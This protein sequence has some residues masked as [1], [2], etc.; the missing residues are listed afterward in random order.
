MVLVV[1]VLMLIS[2][3]TLAI[4]WTTSELALVF[5][6]MGSAAAAGVVLTISI[7]RNRPEEVFSGGGTH[8]DADDSWE[9][10]PARS[11]RIARPAA[12]P[13]S[14]SV[15]VEGDVDE[16]DLS[17]DDDLDDEEYDDEEGLQS[18]EDLPIAD[19]DELS[20]SE[21][22][23]LLEELDLDELEEVREHEVAN[24]S[25]RTVLGQIDSLLDELSVAEPAAQ[26]GE[27]LS[28]E[29][30]DEEY[31][32]EEEEE[33]EELD[34]EEEYEDEEDEELEDE[35]EDEEPAGEDSFPIA[36][37]DDLKSSEILPLL[38]QLYPD[39]LEI[40]WEHENATRARELVLAR[41]DVLLEEEEVPPPRRTAPKP[42]RPAARKPAAPARRPAAQEAAPPRRPAAKKP[43]APVRKPA[44]PARPP[45]RKAVPAR[46]AARKATAKAKAPTRKVASAVKKT[47]KKSVA[48]G[49]PIKN[50][51]KLAVPDIVRRLKRLSAAE[52]KAVRTYERR[53]KGRVTLLDQ[54]DSFIRG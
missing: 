45:A 16:A 8:D 10:R 14:R 46:P 47:V 42:P 29:E 30:D 38:P 33:L 15:F 1:M 54:I 2:M 48:A 53:N 24:R 5:A 21:I 27:A 41:I 7:L 6:S 51:D 28:Y 50:Y 22:L 44:A 25:R 32:D 43:A 11:A 52:L 19:Y 4:G 26:G 13:R 37:Y 20:V 40:V 3:A 49:P 36:D 12:A 23:P 34:E 35:E 17:W 39:E 31:E 9:P 18:S